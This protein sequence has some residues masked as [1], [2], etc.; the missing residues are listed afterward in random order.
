[1]P[2]APRAIAPLRPEQHIPRLRLCARE[3]FAERGVVLRLGRAGDGDVQGLTG[4]VLCQAGA[5]E[6]AA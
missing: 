2:H 6:A 3:V 1:M 4:G 5:V